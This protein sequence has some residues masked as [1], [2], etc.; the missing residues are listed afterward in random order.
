MYSIYQGQSPAWWD[1][2]GRGGVKQPEVPAPCSAMS[3]K[4]FVSDLRVSRLLPGSMKMWQANLLACKSD[5]V[6]DTLQF[7]TDLSVGHS[8]GYDQE[9]DR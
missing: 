7:L 8:S 2:R 6:L 3:N 9:E 4:S 5:T 1:L